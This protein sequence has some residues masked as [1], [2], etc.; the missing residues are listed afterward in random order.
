ME[1]EI[2]VIGIVGKCSCGELVDIAIDMCPYVTYL[3][4]KLK[5]IH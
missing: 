4:R 1:F 2:N 3:F 5:K